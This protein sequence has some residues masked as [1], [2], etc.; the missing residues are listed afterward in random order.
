MSNNIFVELLGSFSFYLI[1]LH[2]VHVTHVRIHLE[3]VLGV[4]LDGKFAQSPFGIFVVGCLVEFQ[5][6]AYFVDNVDIKCLP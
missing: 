2:C 5:D 3:V 6:V 4:E 1:D